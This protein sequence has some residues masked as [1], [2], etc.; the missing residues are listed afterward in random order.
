[1]I[2]KKKIQAYA[3]GKIIQMR[4]GDHWCN[5]LG[6]I[7]FNRPVSLYRIKPNPE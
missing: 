5:D 7:T 1:M 4:C 2:D 6:D 3:E